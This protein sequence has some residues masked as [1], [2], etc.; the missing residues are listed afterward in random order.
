[1]STA[2]ET[3]GS[4]IWEGLTWLHHSPKSNPVLLQ[5]ASAKDQL[6]HTERRVALEML[7]RVFWGREKKKEKRKRRE[8]KEGL[9]F[10]CLF[11][12]I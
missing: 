5:G 1:M 2:W 3:L 6:P 11:Q 7:E 8:G 4:T 10:E 12:E 9:L